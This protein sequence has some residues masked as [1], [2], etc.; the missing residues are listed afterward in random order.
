ME[1]FYEQNYKMSETEFAQTEADSP[2]VQTLMLNVGSMFREF[3]TKLTPNNYDALVVAVAA[4]CS[5]QLERAIMKTEFNR[6]GSMA[7]DKVV[8]TLIN[9]FSGASAWPVREKFSRLVQVTTV[10]NLERVSDIDE[11]L[12][13]DSGLRF[14]WKLTPDIIKQ[15]L[16]LRSDF[17]E[18]DIRRIKL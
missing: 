17:R 8:R 1:P 16:K 10:L 11:F 12:N 14:S 7:L 15:I 18:E 9:Y 6:L 5:V 3:Q 13:P 2:F 4:E